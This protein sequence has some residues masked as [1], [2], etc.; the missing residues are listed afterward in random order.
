MADYSLF[1]FR[2]RE[3]IYGVDLRRTLFPALVQRSKRIG[4]WE[5][6]EWVGECVVVGVALDAGL[7]QKMG[8][9][10]I[11]EGT[12]LSRGGE[13]EIRVFYLVVR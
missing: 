12:F 9:M 5:G 3:K 1:S 4:R 13:I 2:D 10:L 8:G 11:Y 7:T 6:K